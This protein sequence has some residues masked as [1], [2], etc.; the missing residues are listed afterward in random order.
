VKVRYVC[1]CCRAIIAEFD[2]PSLTDD[3]LRL[4][5][6]TSVDQDQ[7]MQQLA[8][9]VVLSTLCDECAEVLSAAKEH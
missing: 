8:D 2:D 5:Q 9:A 6:L 7:P 3:R 1:D 4:D